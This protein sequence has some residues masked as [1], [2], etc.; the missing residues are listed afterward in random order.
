[1]ADSAC[2]VLAA[3]H[4]NGTTLHSQAGCGV[5]QT[6]GDFAKMNGAQ[7]AA[8]WRALEVRAR[9]A[10]GAPLPAGLLSC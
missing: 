1:M 4:I 5:P 6:M 10:P 2:G 8:R 3:T 7:A 9:Q